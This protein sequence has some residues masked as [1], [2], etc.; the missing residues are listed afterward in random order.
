MSRLG[1]GEEDGISLHVDRK[2]GEL[3]LSTSE[4]TDDGCR[5]GELSTARLLLRESEPLNLES[6]FA[7][8]SARVT[9][10]EL[11][12]VRSHFPVPEID[13]SRWRLTVRGLREISFGLEELRQMPA[14][15]RT[16]TLE[17]AGNGRVA[18]TPSVDGVQWHLG[19][20]STAEWTG[21]P[22]TAVLERAGVP[23]GSVEVVFEGADR[24][25]PRA[26]PRPPGPIAY[27]HGVPVEHAGDVLL[28]WAMN[29]EPLS[30]EH[31]FPLRAVVSGYYAMVA[32]KWLTRIQ[33]LR[34]PFQGYYKTTDYAYWDDSHGIPE[35]RPL[36]RMPL[37]SQI[38]RPVAGEVVRAGSTVMVVGAAWTGG[39]PV[40][41][42]EV[43][44]DGGATWQTAEILDEHEH[45]VWRRWQWAWRVPAKTGEYALMSRAVDRE[46]QMQPAERDPRFGTYCIHHSVPVVVRVR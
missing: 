37:K 38:A 16:V 31:G 12:Y 10:S 29:G 17:C 20:V 25:K 26:T 34:E 44:A 1:Q 3:T 6:P 13:A 33:V 41:R 46:G 11:F 23:P 14:E 4:T 9:P 21:V 42:V 35:Q 30:R 24:G 43:S 32:V 45:G 22:L 40:E 2:S 19:A 36:A 28:A 5:P 39:A 18:L 8:L 15:T 27:T 7:E